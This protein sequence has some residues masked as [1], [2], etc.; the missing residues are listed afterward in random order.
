M[1]NENIIAII[2]K[3]CVEKNAPSVLNMNE[4]YTLLAH[5][6]YFVRPGKTLDKFAAKLGSIMKK[7]AIEGAKQFNKRG[8]G[9]PIESCVCTKTTSSFLK[10]ARAF[11]DEKYFE[12]Q[13]LRMVDEEHNDEKLLDKYLALFDNEAL[14][15]FLWLVQYLA[16]NHALFMEL[17]AAEDMDSIINALC[18]EVDASIP[19]GHS[20]NGE[21]MQRYFEMLED[22]RWYMFDYL[23]K[24]TIA[25]IIREHISDHK[26]LAANAA[27]TLYY[28]GDPN[29]AAF[30]VIM[31]KTFQ[32]FYGV[33]AFEATTYALEE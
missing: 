31:T 22:D 7:G 3:F 12:E 1:R 9:C 13:I 16:W 18:R 33:D 23:N 19:N 11:F 21:E 8:W 5:S 4:V 10:V 20:D 26:I 25:S 30:Y 2:K 15:G 14:S 32:R 29:M 6:Y 17:K 28:C 24:D 27:K